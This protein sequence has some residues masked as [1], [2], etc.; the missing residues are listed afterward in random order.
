MATKRTHEDDGSDPVTGQWC[1]LDKI[2]QP[3]LQDIGFFR[4]PLSNIGFASTLWGGQG[5]ILPHVHDIAYDVCTN[6]T[7]ARRY[8]TVF[9]VVVPEKNKAAWRNDHWWKKYLLNPLF[10]TCDTRDMHY[11]CL[12]CTHFVG[13]HKLIAE[14]NRTFMDKKTVFP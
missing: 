8:R 12:K 2:A 6:M 10:P 9:L 14:G 11:A 7:S 1:Y 5:F 3:F 4:I 13:A